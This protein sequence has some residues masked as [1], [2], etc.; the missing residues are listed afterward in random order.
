MT[1]VRG[2]VL[3]YTKDG[4]SRSTQ[5]RLTRKHR[6]VLQA[7][8]VAPGT[9]GCTLRRLAQVRDPALSGLID[10]LDDA[11]LLHAEKDMTGPGVYARRV[12]YRLTAQGRKVALSA[13]GLAS[14]QGLA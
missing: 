7:L 1:E 4:A 9:T 10:H 11:G 3:I 12:Y 5:V 8:L 6:R 13:L 14:E 2:G